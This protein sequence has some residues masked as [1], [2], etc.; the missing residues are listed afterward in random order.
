MEDE[1]GGYLTGVED[2][3]RIA[4]K[5]EELAANPARALKWDSLIR[6][7]LKNSA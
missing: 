2:V 6:R 1:K 4:E 7:K 5:I 3:E